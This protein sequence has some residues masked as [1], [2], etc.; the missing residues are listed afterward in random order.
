VPDIVSFVHHVPVDLSKR[1]ELDAAR[2]GYSPIAAW[3]VAAVKDGRLDGSL[4]LKSSE[5]DLTTIVFTIISGLSAQ[6][7]SGIA[8]F[9]ARSRRE[10]DGTALTARTK[11]RLSRDKSFRMFDTAELCAAFS[12]RNLKQLRARLLSLGIMF[13]YQD[14]TKQIVGYSC[15][16][17]DEL[18]IKVEEFSALNA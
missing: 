14:M 17:P 15:D 10:I 4:T 9:E 7:L 1:R 8:E 6:V 12:C 3:L 18:R 2:A 16:L 13:W 5:S 11:Q